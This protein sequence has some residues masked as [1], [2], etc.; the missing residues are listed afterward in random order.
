MQMSQGKGGVQKRGSPED[1]LHL[2]HRARNDLAATFHRASKQ[3]VTCEQAPR[4]TH[5]VSILRPS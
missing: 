5:Q 3:K 4:A 1:M 2:S